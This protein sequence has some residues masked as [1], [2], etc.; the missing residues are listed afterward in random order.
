MVMF[1]ASYIL[2]VVLGLLLT[3]IV[4]QA[5]AQPH[6]DREWVDLVIVAPPGSGFVVSNPVRYSNAGGGVYTRDSGSSL[7]VSGSVGDFGF[8]FSSFDDANT[9]ILESAIDHAT[10]DM[11]EFT[12]DGHAGY[13]VQIYEWGPEPDDET[14]P[15]K[16]V[17]IQSSVAGQQTLFYGNYQDW[18]LSR[19]FPGTNYTSVL[20]AIGNTWEGTARVDGNTE[21]SSSH[22]KSP[23][24]WPKWTGKLVFTQG[25][26]AYYQSA[27]TYEIIEWGPP[28][29][30][31]DDPDDPQPPDDDP[32]ATG[33][34]GDDD[35]PDE[36][37]E[38][39][40]PLGETPDP[41]EPPETDLSCLDE[42]LADAADT[43]LV[44]LIRAYQ[45]DGV[46]GVS[47]DFDLGTVGGVDM[48]VGV[49][50]DFSG[51]PVASAA[52]TLQGWTRSI[53]MVFVTYLAVLGFG[54]MLA[55]W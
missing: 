25:N 14:G 49:T 53:S 42:K 34:G 4:H 12:G 22:S 54:K 5:T 13:S 29:N 40:D 39:D 9:W 38:P 35:E 48:S 17:V 3:M 23:I 27:Q 7:T 10:G 41:P 24:P 18:Y 26:G 1:K 50:T 16:W 45:V 51:T 37:D 28:Y 8:V 15:F 20:R 36:P 32:G 30:Q 46:D 6:D 44:Q 11:V 47:M 21:D 31:P 43:A 2:A 55:F 33:G 19:A 52:S